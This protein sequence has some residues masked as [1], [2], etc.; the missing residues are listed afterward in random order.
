M[1]GGLGAIAF[2]AITCG[3]TASRAGLFPG[4]PLLPVARAKTVSPS[5]IV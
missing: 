3:T 5:D 4:N 2:A 1:P